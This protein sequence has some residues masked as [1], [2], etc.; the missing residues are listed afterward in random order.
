MTRFLFTQEPQLI[1][2]LS[3][4]RWRDRKSTAGANF[5]GKDWGQAGR[6]RGFGVNSGDGTTS[7]PALPDYKAFE[8]FLQKSL[9]TGGRGPAVWRGT[10]GTC[11]FAVP[12][13]V[14]WTKAA[15]RMFFLRSPPRLRTNFRFTGCSVLLYPVKVIRTFPAFPE[16]I[17]GSTWK[18]LLIS[19]WA[20]YGERQYTI[21][22]CRMG[23]YF[24][25]RQ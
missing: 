25:G 16:M 24:P 20:L 1:V 6:S 5:F 21:G 4:S 19:R 8:R 17:S 22:Q 14:S 13:K 3:Y 2:L 23:Q 18:S 7:L 12:V 11:C 9:H 10:S 15:S